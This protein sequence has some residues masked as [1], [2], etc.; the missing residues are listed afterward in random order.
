MNQERRPRGRERRSGRPALSFPVTRRDG[1][2]PESDARG[3]LDR[4]T[5]G[6]IS[7]FRLFHG[8][9]YGLVEHVVAACELRDFPDEQLLLKRGDI[10]THVALVISGQ[11][12]IHLDSPDSDDFIE[13]AAGECAGEMSIIDG[14]PV[15][16]Y[17]VADAGCR[18]LLMEGTAFLNQVL[19][20]P[21]VAR[22]L[23]TAFAERMRANNGL[24]IRR[25]KA[26]M[27][28]QRLQRELRFARSIQA[29]LMPQRKPFFPER[30]DVDCAAH[31]TPAREVGG[32]FY[33]AFLVDAE[34]LFLTIGDV[35]GKGMPASL[36]MVRTLTLLRSEV[37]RRPPHEQPEIRTVM[38]RVNRLLNANN[39]AQMFSSVFAALLDLESGRLRY[40]NAGHNPPLLF[41]P[42]GRCEFLAEPRNPVLGIRDG[43]EYRAGAVTLAAGSALL[44]YTDG[45][46]EAART[47]GELFGEERLLTVLGRSHDAGA[48]ALID[49]AL[50][51]VRS[52][53]G[54]AEQS[55]DVTLLALRYTG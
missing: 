31:I 29:G 10:N 44:L 46:T 7:G 33:D 6:F 4:R 24:I 11:L 23:M 51:A 2:R 41:P 25:T 1:T 35:C 12:R 37:A 49:A 27:E 17:V 22:N 18:L 21:E 5:L 52:F 38:Y 48:A 43:L 39:E 40:V 36:L 34:T 19:I 32:D 30:P 14:E 26:A 55:D 42:H 16:A 8:V 45:V 50:T 13:I 54:G 47:S 28:L 9:P 20:I 53:A 15:S 3:G